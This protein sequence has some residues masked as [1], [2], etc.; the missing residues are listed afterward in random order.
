M[1][2]FIESFQEVRIDSANDTAEFGAVGQVTVTSKSDTNRLHGSAFEYY[3]S[4]GFAS[5]NPFSLTKRSWLNHTPGVSAGG[6]I[7]FPKLYS[8]KNKR[9]FFASWESVKGS[10]QSTLLNPTV[11][12]EPRR[13]GDFSALAP[14]T[15]VR[16]PMANN[17]PFANNPPGSKTEGPSAAGVVGR[18]RR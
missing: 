8:G 17:S 14:G 7:L 9:F 1:Q 5:R 3:D 2:G 12:L 13:R 16:D 18:K 10:R 6:P 15:I 4:S 11:P